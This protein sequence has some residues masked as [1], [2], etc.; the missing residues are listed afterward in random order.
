V[1]VLTDITERKRVEEER[2]R[3]LEELREAN[4]LAQR[5]HARW[6]AVVETMLDPVTVGDAQGRAI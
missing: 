4:W 2:E 1:V 5:E 6:R 3:L